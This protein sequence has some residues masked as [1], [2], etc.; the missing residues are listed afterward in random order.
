MTASSL[1]DF[2]D[3]SI[4]DC[5]TLIASSPLG[6]IRFPTGK[7]NIGWNEPYYQ[8]REVAHNYFGKVTQAL[9][10]DITGEPSW[11]TIPNN[12]NLVPAITQ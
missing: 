8:Q 6:C 7:Y 2:D 11:I 12:A 9:V 1:T 4:E 3:L 5:K 10:K